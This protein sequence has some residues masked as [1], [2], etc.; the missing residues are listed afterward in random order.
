MSDSTM[1]GGGVLPSPPLELPSSMPGFWQTGAC[2]ET[3]RTLNPGTRRV[4][5]AR[6][7]PV[8]EIPGETLCPAPAACPVRG[9]RTRPNGAASR[10]LAHL[11]FGGFWSVVTV[12]R[13]RARR[14]RR[15]ARPGAWP[16][17]VQLVVAG[18]VTMIFRV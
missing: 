11:P 4:P 14:P 17:C 8:L 1:G 10:G 7:F 2:V 13:P 16:V 15:S 3:S 18:L 12:Y 6:S 9:G 5:R